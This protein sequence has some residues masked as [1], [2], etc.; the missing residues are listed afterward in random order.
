MTK[1]P[2]FFI[3]YANLVILTV[4]GIILLGISSY[5]N[6]PKETFPQI[7]IPYIVVNTIYKGVAPADI[8]TL[9]TKPIEKKIKSIT[10]IKKVSSTSA[11]SFSSI[12]I[13]FNTDVKI[14]DALQK[15]RDK[16]SAAKADL[17]KEAEDSDVKEISFDDIP[18]MVIS[19]SGDYGLNRLKEVADNLKD[20]FETI[21]GVLNVNIVGGL[22]REIQVLVNPA[23]LRAHGFSL[24]NYTQALSLAN[25]SVPGG[26]ID[27][28]DTTYLIRVPDDY[29]N[30]EEIKNTVIKSAAGK[31]VYVKDV[32][33]VIDTY[34]TITSKTR[35]NKKAAISISIQK[36][37]GANVIEII[38]KV[39]KIIKEQELNFPTGTKLEYITDEGKDIADQVDE[40]E[41]S[42]IMSLILVILVIYLF[43]GFRNSLIAAIVI[44]LCM[45]MSFI[46]LKSIDYRLNFMVLFALILMSGMLV[47]D[48][49]V[50]VENSFRHLMNGSDQKKAA[51]EGA[52]EV[53]IPVLTS[54]LT[55]IFAFLPLILWP[56]MIGKFLGYLPKTVMTGLIASFVCAV[57]INPV[58]CSL[59]LR[60]K[61][62]EKDQNGKETITY[63][64]NNALE[65]FKSKYADILIWAIANNKRVIKWAFGAFFVS[66]FLLATIPKEFFPKLTPKEFFVDVTMPIGTRLATTDKVSGDLENYLGKNKNINYILTNVGNR[67]AS[68]LL[69]DSSAARLTVK[70]LDKNKLTENPNKIM[71]EIREFLRQIPGVKAE[72]QTPHNGPPAGS[73]ISIRISGPDF[74]QLKLQS[75]KVQEIMRTVEH[76]VDIQDNLVEGRPEIHI[77]IDRNKT[78]LYGLNAMAVALQVRTA[79]NGVS[80]TKFRT[81]DDEYDITVKLN[82]K[83]IIDLS[84][85]A[86]F[87]V[88]SRTGDSVPL[89]KI[90]TI[91]NTTGFG[92][93]QRE[94]YER[95]INVRADTDGKKLPFVALKE[96]QKKL[97]GFKLP[98][99]Y[100]IM[101]TGENEEM[102]KSF[103]FLGQAFQLALLLIAIT[104]VAQFNSYVLPLII[105]T[106][107]MLSIVG[108]VFG[109]FITRNPFGLMA[110]IGLIAL[111]GVVVKNGI[112]LIEFI[113]VMREKGMPKNEA[114]IEACKIR[115]RPVFLT[116]I[117]T[118][119]GLLPTA[120]R[121]G[122]NFKKFTI[123]FN[124][125]SAAYWGP[126]ASVIVFGLLVSTVLT[127]VVVPTL[128]YKVDEMLENRKNKKKLAEPPASNPVVGNNNQ[129]R[130]FS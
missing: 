27:L 70:L 1:W 92:S 58:L 125:D 38:D 83:N 100:K 59:F 87:T 36:R 50:V 33:N 55:T 121:I 84:S 71:N 41:N 123:D 129:P 44:P 17:P 60:K 9:I 28:G 72:I 13:E 32:A 79:F 12:F 19:L 18:I 117:T 66:L 53:I 113:I 127:L 16:V 118:I 115:L 45:L 111:A 80:A 14:D 99:G 101:Y 48:A 94:N 54:T 43:M 30:V 64:A 51:E 5:K 25:V 37:S 10:G 107:I 20:E 65:N 122:V 114:I 88:V 102:Q 57:A 31:N 108:A 39:K 86:N 110:F 130:I 97:K 61:S 120:L 6:M 7:E 73:P 2:K 63:R 124:G 90:A 24:D 85:L 81:G 21:T 11:E 42:L 128:Y 93:I 56:G 89:A 62:Y 67:G 78:A 126:L 26:T 40:M 47:D 68:G 8:E 105:M 96:I 82:E 3:K 29:K 15:V 91:T 119:L 69:D 103:A 76:V 74:K 4:I 98:E 77:D 22:E 95:Y 109:L 49:I 46:V 34:K 116:A 75:L 23:Q 104:L 35:L 112:L 106:T 52:S